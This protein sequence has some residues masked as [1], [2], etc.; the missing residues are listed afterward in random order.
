M[1]GDLRRDSIAQVSR[2]SCACFHCEPNLLRRSVGMTDRHMHTTFAQRGDVSRCFLP[3][4]RKSDEPDDSTGSMLP[5]I[6]LV[7]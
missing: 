1:A 7:D 3:V 2:Q 6:E 4:R 5:A